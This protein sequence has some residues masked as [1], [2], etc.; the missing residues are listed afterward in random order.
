MP[1]Y[2]AYNFFTVTAKSLEEAQAEAEKKAPSKSVTVV[3]EG[4]DTLA[5]PIHL[6]TVH[7]LTGFVSAHDDG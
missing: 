1:K 5:H 6:Q 7:D 2:V 3:A 4:L